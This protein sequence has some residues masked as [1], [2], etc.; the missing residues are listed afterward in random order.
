MNMNPMMTPSWQNT[1]WQASP[2]SV[3]STGADREADLSMLEAATNPSTQQRRRRQ[4]PRKKTSRKKSS[5]SD[6]RT[7]SKT[8]QMTEPTSCPPPL[9]NYSNSDTKSINDQK[10]P[11]VQNRRSIMPVIT[12]SQPKPKASTPPGTSAVTKKELGKRQYNRMNSEP[13]FPSCVARDYFTPAEGLAALP[14]FPSEQINKGLAA[15]NEM[16]IGHLY[17]SS[18]YDQ[19]PRNYGQFYRKS[20]SCDQEKLDRS[21]D[22]SIFLES[23]AVKEAEDI[24]GACD[25]QKYEWEKDSNT[26]HRQDDFA[27]APFSFTQGPGYSDVR[28]RSS[29][30]PTFNEVHMNIG[31]TNKASARGFYAINQ[32]QPMPQIITFPSAREEGEHHNEKRSSFEQNVTAS[33][34]FQDRFY[35]ADQSRPTPQ[36]ASFPSASKEAEHQNEKRSSLEQSVTASHLFQDTAASGL[37]Q[38][39]MGHNMGSFDDT[40]SLLD[41]GM[42]P[43]AT[44]GTTEP[45]GKYSSALSSQSDII[46]NS[47]AKSTEL[48]TMPEEQQEPYPII[49]AQYQNSLSLLRHMKHHRQSA[50]LLD[51]P[52]LD[53]IVGETL[54]GGSLASSVAE[55]LD[56]H[57]LAS[58]AG[59]RYQDDLQEFMEN[60]MTGSTAAPNGKSAF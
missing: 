59:D 38:H 56:L 26:E 32:T 60:E 52:H 11:R 27:K 30:D 42:D 31:V 51:A 55:E 14:L 39:V 53:A 28:T 44:N 19:P 29:T 20:I 8:D 33:D 22:N 15:P 58:I 36:V 17:K 24:L 12:K 45:A 13:V 41:V 16:S 47:V 40:G 21:Y 5:S 57:S 18:C 7:A 6:R 25:F 1:F 23:S 50:P 54:H 46:R 37:F 48:L 35:S 10:T 43:F 9:N 34:L 2:F 49:N 4:Q 3:T